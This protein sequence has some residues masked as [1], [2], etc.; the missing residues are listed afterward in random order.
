MST[1]AM[2]KAVLRGLSRGI[3]LSATGDTSRLRKLR[4]EAET[5]DY[6][7]LAWK[8]VGERMQNSM[9]NFSN[10]HPEVRRDTSSLS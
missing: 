4:K 9:D 7:A 6:T 5:T 3:Y 1:N 10:Q 8:N 2:N